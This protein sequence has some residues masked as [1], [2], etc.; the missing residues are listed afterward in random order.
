[1][2]LIGR[3]IWSEATRRLKVRFLSSVFSKPIGSVC[4]VVVSE[5]VGSLNS[6]D[7]LCREN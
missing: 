4:V 2:L 1:M 3:S 6:K 5:I 7:L